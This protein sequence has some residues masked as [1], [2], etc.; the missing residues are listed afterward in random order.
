MRDTRGMREVVGME[1]SEPVAA[2]GPWLI[3]A[4]L[5]RYAPEELT[6]HSITR[7][8]PLPTASVRSVERRPVE[9]AAP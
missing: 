5:D 8:R 6:H 3:A 2:P 4:I 7:S 1:R 9:A